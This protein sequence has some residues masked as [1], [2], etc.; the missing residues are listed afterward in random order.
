MMCKTNF[1]KSDTGANAAWKGFSTQTLYISERLANEKDNKK[2]WPETL[3]DLMITDNDNKTL[4]LVQIKNLSA[5]LSISDLA[6]AKQSINGEGFFRRSLSKKNDNPILKVVYFGELGEEIRGLLNDDVQSKNSIRGKL[7]SN[8]GIAESDT[9]WIL[10]QLRFEKV[11]EEVLD[12]SLRNSM[13]GNINTMAAPELA[14]KLII[15]YISYLSRSK[16]ATSKYIWNNEMAKIG[17]ELAALDGFFRENNGSLIRLSDLSTKQTLKELS[18]SYVM[19]I[20]V[21]PDHIRNNL[22]LERKQWLDEIVKSVEENFCTIVNGVSG[23]GKSSLCYRYLLNNYTEE[24]IFCIRQIKSV[25]QAEN[26]IKALNFIANQEYSIVYIDINNIN[27]NYSY[28]LKEIFARRIA[29]KVLISIRAEDY[30][31]IEADILEVPLNTI[32]VDF[33]EC[34]AKELF[35][36]SIKKQPNAKFREFDDIWN[37]FGGKGPL[38]EFMYLLNNSQTLKKKIEGQI[39]SLI[40]EKIDDSW[41]EVLTIVSYAGIYGIGI[42][43]SKIKKLTNCSNITS[44]IQRFSKEYMIRESEDKIKLGVLHPVRGAIIYDVLKSMTYESETDICIKTISCATCDY[45][46]SMMMHYFKRNNNYSEFIERLCN[47]DLSSWTVLKE[48]LY[49]LLWLDVGTY[50]KANEKVI[51]KIKEEHNE[52]WRLFLPIDLSG[53]LEMGSQTG[54]E[55]FASIIV[56]DKV[57]QAEIINTAK[58]YLDELN[59]KQYEYEFTKKFIKGY[60]IKLPLPKSDSD[61]SSFGYVLFWFSKLDTFIDLLSVSSL[62]NY[63]EQFNQGLLKAKTEALRGIYYQGNIELYNVCE[64][65][66][67]GRIIAEEGVL[68]YKVDKNEVYCTLTIVEE[69]IKPQVENVQFFYLMKMVELL[70][71]IYPEKEYIHVKLIGVD[72]LSE[73]NITIP[74]KEK[75]IA[76]EN[77]VCKWISEINSW[78]ITRSAYNERPENWEQFSDI[79]LDK[80]SFLKSLLRKFL[81]VIDA[82][83]LKGK[84][85]EILYQDFRRGFEKIHKKS[86]ILLPKNIVDETYLVSEQLQNKE[87]TDKDNSFNNGINIESKR[88]ALNSYK[89]FLKNINEL[90]TSTENFINM[91]EGLLV[92]QIRILKNQMID[93]EEYDKLKRLSRYNIVNAYKALL[94]VQSEYLH[95]F[96]RYSKL[97]EDEIKEQ[98]EIFENMIIMCSYYSKYTINPNK[99]MRNKIS[100][101]SKIRLS[102]YEAFTV[103]KLIENIKEQGFI[104]KDSDAIYCIKEF[105]ITSDENLNGIIM[106]IVNGVQKKFEEIIEPTLMQAQAEKS[107]RDIVFIPLINGKPMICGFIIPYYRFTTKIENYEF[108]ILPYEVPSFIYNSMLD[109]HEKICIENYKEVNKLVMIFKQYNDVI[110]ELQVLTN[111]ERCV[112]QIDNFVEYLLKIVYEIKRNFIDYFGCYYNK[113]NSEYSDYNSIYEEIL[114][115]IQIS[116]EEMKEKV[117]TSNSNINDKLFMAYFM[118]M[119]SFLKA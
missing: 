48:I 59:M 56:E 69:R 19:G 32:E 6:T 113:E 60:C 17:K 9:D 116:I 88:V 27:D 57:K 45:I 25:N 24:K 84:N 82:V 53:M 14:R 22:D 66:L 93:Q 87:S 103:E 85:D 81:Y 73:L 44:A 100:Y 91:S 3:E 12:E 8:H 105:D 37:V 55:K 28:F 83:Y 75:K 51:Q 79:I 62:D 96:N 10:G 13:K 63:K 47:V 33:S 74:D 58:Q 102:K 68:S 41:I 54:G 101:E 94:N 104:V 112:I 109:E 110:R 78:V 43:Q 107:W 40:R 64:N 118:V 15:Q 1:N 11:S 90:F 97:R 39:Q 31:K 46:S 20:S 98:Q 67:R 117:P 80:I 72:L 36:E 95:L 16:G 115:I 52:A 106:K 86:C 34:E 114:S 18:D 29:T 92:N 89:G 30:I 61:W 42:D 50:Y 108:S 23:Q 119:M 2:Y 38:L 49:S 76:R 70:D 4:E 111:K 35:N 21:H 99:K 26:L 71:N 65:V 5:K 7:I 77:R